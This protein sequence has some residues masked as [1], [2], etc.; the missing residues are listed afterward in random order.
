MYH[1]PQTVKLWSMLIKNSM[2]RPTV[3]E[4]LR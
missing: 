3:M 4:D 1:R 2:E